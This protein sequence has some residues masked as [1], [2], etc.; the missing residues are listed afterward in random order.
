MNI[1]FCCHPKLSA[2]S[3]ID[4][5]KKL[6]VVLYDYPLYDCPEYYEAAF[7]FRDIES[8][9]DFLQ[10]C[11]GEL[12]ANPVRRTLEIGCG[13]APHAGELVC[14]GHQYTGLDINRNMLQYAGDK[15]ETV[16]AQLSL[17]AGVSSFLIP[18]YPAR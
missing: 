4:R 2:N 5:S 11:I 17:V 15:W 12:L 9:A 10:T 16:G 18:W 3:Q 1:L 7:S 8:E 14:K 13:H 6:F